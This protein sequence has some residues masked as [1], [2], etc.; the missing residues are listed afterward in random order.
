MSDLPTWLTAL[1][2]VVIPGFGEPPEQ[3]YNGYIEADYLYVAPSSS[4]RITAI[5]AREGQAVS[6]GE[7][8][9]KLEDDSQRAALHAAE[10]NVAVAR[11]NLDNLMTGSRD[12][13]I[14]VIRASLAN[15]EAE[16]HLAQITLDRSLQLSEKGLVPPAK[17]D[18]D[19]A[20]LE[21]ANAQVAQLKAQLHVA[22]L[23]ARGAQQLAAEAALDG[24][25]AELDRA[26]SDLRNRV[27]VVP[28]SGLVDR[29]YFD[30]G[31]VAATGAPVVSI[32]QP[33]LL[34]VIFFVPE[35]QRAD[36]TVGE[37]LLISCDGCPDDL[38]AS[39]SRLSPSPQHTPPILYSRDERARLVFRAEAMITDA[40]GLLPG[41]PVTVGPKP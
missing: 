17:V 38:T 10:A 3:V 13:E 6:A 21:L 33:D 9:V 39:V 36:I 14:E 31:E 35:P 12:A 41:Q 19:R 15:A 30:V 11:A 32:F 22:E 2:A 24:A 20:R 29:I 7:P 4:G 16:Q 26:R 28:T 27:I 18:N 8:L 37:G 23:P 5:D 25:R 40:Q 34:K 1:V